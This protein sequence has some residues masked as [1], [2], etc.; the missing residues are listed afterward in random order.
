MLGK[1]IKYDLRS[2]LRK[3]WMVWVGILALA[4]INGF[5]IGHVL[6]NKSFTGLWA[7]ILGVL[8]IILLG[9]LGVAMGVLILVFICERFYRGLLGDEGYLMFTL[10]ATTA[11]HIGS[12]AIVALILE[13]ISALVAVAAGFLLLTVLDATGFFRG[14]REALGFLRELEYPRGFGLLIAELV[15]LGV[16]GTIASTLQI[17][18]A[19]AIGHLAKKHRAAWSVVAFVGINTALSI[20][21][22]TGLSSLERPMEWI[23]R[24]TISFDE[25]GIHGTLNGAAAAFG[26]VLLEQLILGV[27]FFFGTKWILD[28][29]LNL[30]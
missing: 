26:I 13:V 28:K 11:E 16:V 3:F 10:P 21:S 20:L 7:F 25:T 2:C 1:L 22:F 29:K 12:K 14:F 9:V 23:T 18:Q 6:N 27:I 24:M 19:I 15:V 4:A 17:Y 8:P 5:T 30:E